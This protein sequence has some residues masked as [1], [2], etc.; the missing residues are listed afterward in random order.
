MNWSTAKG[1]SHGWQIANVNQ[2]IALYIGMSYT[3]FS[4]NNRHIGS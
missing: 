3:T 4:N 1:R 2:S